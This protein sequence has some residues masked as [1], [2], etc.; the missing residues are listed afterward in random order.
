M[1]ALGDN[2][3]ILSEQIVKQIIEDIKKGVLRPG[4]KLPPEK[5]LIELY[6][7]SRGSVR[8]ALRTLKIMN[9]IDI[10]QGKGAFVTSLEASLLV[11]HL[12]FVFMLEETTIFNLFEARRIIEPELAAIAA[13]RASDE[14][15]A[16]MRELIQGEEGVDI[17]LHQKIAEATR[18]P[19]LI[20]FLSS[21]WSL[22]EISRQRTSKLP[23]VKE[24][25][26]RGHTQLVD[27]IEE[28]N[29][30]KARKL[31][32]EHIA[33]VEANYRRSAGPKPGKPEP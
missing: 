4:D 32:R 22:G 31:M 29:P 26:Y 6:K 24:K 13:I 3:A 11:E 23:G 2:K 17:E 33:F 18:N 25:A 7:V 20:R 16:E 27:A 14:E 30:E 10:Q 21:V 8:E 15:I 1:Q 9:V 12:E 19:I 28:H 5:K